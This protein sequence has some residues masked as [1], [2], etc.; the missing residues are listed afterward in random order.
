MIAIIDY[1][2]GNLAS[3][4]NAMDRLMA[5][6]MITNRLADLDQADA[7]IFPGVG[8][9]APAMRDLRQNGLDSWLRSTRKPLLGICLGMQLLY[10]ST[11]EGPTET[12]GILSGRLEKFDDARQK[13]PHMGWNTVEVQPGKE[14]HPL[15]RSI[16]AGTHF[17]HVHSY[18]APVTGDTVAAADYG[19]PFCAIAGRDNFMGVQFHPEKSG[20]AGEQLLRNFLDLVYGGMRTVTA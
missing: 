1:K 14:T 8:H 7:V 6:Y 13:V 15:L 18:Y 3:V 2:A 9:A 4:S 11:T 16:P 10:E 20:K 12:L 17:Y 5:S 19:H